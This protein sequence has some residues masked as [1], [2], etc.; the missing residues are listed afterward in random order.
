MGIMHSPQSAWSKEM[1]KW[2]MRPVQIGDSMVMPLPKSQ[3][4]RAGDA[5]I[6]LEY[7]KLLYK[8]G[9]PTGTG[10]QITG[11]I[12]VHDAS[13][14]RI[15]EGQGWHDGQQRAIDAVHRD[16]QV[17]AQQAAN[18]NF[19]DRRM[20]ENAQAEAHAAESQSSQHLGEIPRKPIKK[21]GRPV[22]QA[23]AGV[24]S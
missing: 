13:E 11:Y 14:Q 17:L 5:D 19:H 21:R 22:K 20:S 9:R 6:H 18:R 7:P 16:D 24:A 2:E 12:Q 3:G 10:V 1:S 15:Q 4:G 8:A 23:P